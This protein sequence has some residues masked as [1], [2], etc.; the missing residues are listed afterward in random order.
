[1]TLC[2]TDKAQSPK[3]DLSEAGLRGWPSYCWR[4]R[5]GRH[6]SRSA[7]NHH[8]CLPLPACLLTHLGKASTVADYFVA[9]FIP[10]V[11]CHGGLGVELCWEAFDARVQ[12]RQYICAASFTTIADIS[13]HFNATSRTRKSISPSFIPAK[14]MCPPRWCGRSCAGNRAR[15][16]SPCRCVHPASPCLD[17]RMT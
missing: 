17:L 12:S 3:G 2:L 14:R 9:I 7:R 4:W 11:N 13:C 10:F 6:A 1:M 5:R 15:V 16:M 8:S